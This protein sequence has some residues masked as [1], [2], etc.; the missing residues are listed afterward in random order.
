MVLIVICGWFVYLTFIITPLL[1][2]RTVLLWIYSCLQ[3]IVKE[4][5]KT[6]GVWDQRPVPFMDQISPQQLGIFDWTAY[7]NEVGFKA[8]C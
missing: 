8:E 1:R 6:A 4:A 5:A 2:M 7:Y 3:F